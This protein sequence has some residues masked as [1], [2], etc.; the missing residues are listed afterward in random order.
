M[1]L[2]VYCVKTVVDE[3]AG[4]YLVCF[5]RGWSN[6]D[7]YRSHLN[8]DHT[9]QLHICLSLCWGPN[10][11]KFFFV[12]CF[13]KKDSSLIPL[14][15]LMPCSFL[16]LLLGHKLFKCKFMQRLSWIKKKADLLVTSIC[17]GC[18]LL[19]AIIILQYYLF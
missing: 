8:V 2:F 10:Q 5:D 4:D 9:I 17:C 3:M 6:K 18:W 16:Y 12:F 15:V 1:T 11:R 19:D 14:I 13:F 7:S